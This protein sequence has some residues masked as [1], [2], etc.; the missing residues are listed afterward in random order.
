MKNIVFAYGFVFLLIGSSFAQPGTAF[1]Y[2]GRLADGSTAIET[3]VDLRFSLLDAS[4]TGSQVGSSLEFLNAA[5]DGGIVQL[6]LDFGTGAFTG[7]PRWL[8]IELANPSG[9]AYTTLTPR[10]QI[11]PTPYSIYSETAGSAL[12]D[13]DTDAANE[14]QTLS[15]SGSELTL[16]DGGGTFSINDADSDSSNELNT[17]VTLNGRMLEVTDA[18]GTQSADLSALDAA[19][20]TAIDSLPFDITASGSY[21]LAA[22]LSTAGGITINSSN[23]TLDLNGFTITNTAGDGI[24]ASAVSN[25]CIQNG[26]VTECGSDGIDVSSAKTVLVQ[27]M[28]V[29]S[30]TLTGIRA[31]N[32]AEIIN[33][34]VN[35][36]M[37]HGIVVVDDCIVRNNNL[38]RNSDNNSEVGLNVTGD[39]NVIEYNRVLDGRRGL[40]VSGTGNYIRENFC[41]GAS[42]TIN[43][44]VSAYLAN[45]VIQSE[46]NQ[47][48]L[49]IAEIPFGMNHSGKA[50][51]TGDLVQANESRPGII[52]AS[53]NVTIDLNGYA[54]IGVGAG[55]TTGTYSGSLDLDDPPD[56]T[57]TAFTTRDGIVIAVDYAD[58]TIKDGTIRNWGAD[59][60]D[61][62][63]DVRNSRFENLILT[64]NDENGL[65]VD[66]SNLIK[67]C[68]ARLNGENG[69]ELENGNVIINCTAE[70]N[71]IDGINAG[72][73]NSIKNCTA[74]FN[75]DAGIQAAQ[76][77]TISGCTA[78][79]NTADGILTSS[80]STVSGCTAN[81]N[82][83][84][85]I[86]LANNCTLVDSTASDNTDNGVE[87][88]VN[89]TIIGCVAED[90]GDRGFDLA[91]NG[92]SI[93]KSTAS[94]NV[95]GGIDAGTA[96]L[97]VEC[98]A[99]D[100]GN[101][102]DD[103]T[104]SLGEDFGFRVANDCTIRNC[105]ADSNGS[106]IAGYAE[107]ED[108]AGIIC[109]S[110]DTR[111]E[112]NSVT[113]NIVGIRVST[114][115]CFIIRNTA[116]T[117]NSSNYNIDANNAYGPI[118]DV[119]GVGD[120]SSTSNANHPWAN[121][122]F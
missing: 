47:L 84:D 10:I 83:D 92:S 68:I 8:S 64:A 58:I 111:I 49:L 13:A 11:L 20:R 98:V 59:G 79:V 51:L 42:N 1:T 9:D 31:G 103:S 23:V 73:S 89:S 72:D 60:I 36:N 100:N 35:E 67:N 107:D 56:T 91:N 45:V 52:I 4:T 80:D 40:Q 32:E 24:L 3:A 62:A 95:F 106:T 120:I 69:F 30:S 14:L 53:D 41:K 50:R 5:Y 15:L 29:T 78:E 96:S 19:S 88:T 121:F 44:S 116:A 97:V 43:L 71:G 81:G 114:T 90:N 55:G 102:S 115:G 16:S 39:N 108:G 12:N 38:A 94:S 57:G 117:N 113:D 105:V 18:G 17:G 66:E 85:G 65:A 22:S 37:E 118:V 7:D 54:L 112:G 119:Q 33:C 87:V 46:G 99:Y 75:E 2:Q 6:D 61:G 122:E 25:V 34:T 86:D 74:S 101:N 77:N 93:F 48:D 76:Y 63:F 26:I 28:K 109:T 82:G 110:N 27:N 21:Y 104:S 70:Y